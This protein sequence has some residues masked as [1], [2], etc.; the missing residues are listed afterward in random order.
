MSEKSLRMLPMKRNSLSTSDIPE[1][2]NLSSKA[3]LVLLVEINKISKK[4]DDVDD[5]GPYSRT[6]MRSPISNEREYKSR[7]QHSGASVTD[8][9]LAENRLQN[10]ELRMTLLKLDSKIDRILLD[11]HVFDENEKDV[12]ITKLESEIDRL[13]RLM[14]FFL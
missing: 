7:G 14:Y 4:A 6:P 8:M 11:K 3:N 9:I 1:L 5:S 10:T 12:K 2:S 13:K